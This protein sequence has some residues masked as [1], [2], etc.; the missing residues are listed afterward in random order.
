MPPTIAW[1]VA[2]ISSRIPLSVPSRPVMVLV[3]V[4]SALLMPAGLLLKALS[5]SDVE[6]REVSMAANALLT[7][8]TPALMPTTTPLMLSR[9]EVR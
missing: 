8:A 7:S 2:L 3:T 9:T 5:A 4:A 1:R 6:P